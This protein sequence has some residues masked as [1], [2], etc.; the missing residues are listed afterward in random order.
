MLLLV[1]IG[2]ISAPATLLPTK[3]DM[4]LISSYSLPWDFSMSSNVKFYSSKV[5]PRVHR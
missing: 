2:G 5:V 1:F 3:Y 4:D